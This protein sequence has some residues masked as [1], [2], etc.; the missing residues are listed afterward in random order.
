MKRLI[1]EQIGRL[2]LVL[3]VVWIG[4]AWGLFPA[5]S[6]SFEE[7][8]ELADYREQVRVE[9]APGQLA[10][11]EVFFPAESADAYR[12]PEM[13]KWVRKKVKAKEFE[14]VPELPE[15]TRAKIIPAPQ[16]LP[17]PGPSLKGSDKLPRW[18]QGLPPLQVP[19]PPTGRR[20]TSSG[21]TGTH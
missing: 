7:E 15:V 11:A 17:D 4:M 8:V 21:K 10:P 9:Y 6:A 12:R 19:E 14:G 16:L 3:A 18:G 5:R 13:A 20:G 2:L 1:E